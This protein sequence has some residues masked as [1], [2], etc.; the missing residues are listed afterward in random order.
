MAERRSDRSRSKGKVLKVK[1]KEPEDTVS[2]WREN[3]LYWGVAL[4]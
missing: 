4:C 3:W 1:A 2:D